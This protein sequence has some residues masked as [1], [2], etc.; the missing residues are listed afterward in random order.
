DSDANTVTVPLASVADGNT[1]NTGLSVDATNL[2]LTDSDA[3][4]VTV[5]LASVADGNTTNTG[6]SVDATNLILTDSDT[7]T[8][9]IPLASV[10]DGNTTN[11]SLTVDATNLILTDSDANTVTVPLASIADGNT[12]YSAGDG[13]NISG[14][15]VISFDTSSLGAGSIPGTIVNPNFGNQNITTSGNLNI[16][17]TGTVTVQG[18]TVHPDYVFQKY[19]LGNSV[20]KESYDF[21]TLAQIEAFVKKYHH[22]PGIQSSAEIKAQG[23]WD[24]GQASKLNLEKIEELFLHTIEQEK[25]ID[26]L[27]YENQSLSAE[28]QSL[29]K[30]ME[31]IK[32]LLK[33]KD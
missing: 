17:G 18:T 14:A 25:K 31:E 24:L 28:L 12:T 8:V 4:T 6:L 33:N 26:Q 7:N 9:T 3:N 27:K 15:N 2:I 32:A 21:K 19:F 30:D 5:P 16:T 29:R 23:F 13:I 20:L 1:T 11:T 22:L 10:A